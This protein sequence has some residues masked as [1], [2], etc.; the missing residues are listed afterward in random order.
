MKKLFLV[1]ISSI[2]FLAH[3][4]AQQPKPTPT[5]TPTG[6]QVVDTTPKAWQIGVGS[7]QKELSVTFDQRMNPGF[8]AWMGRSSLVPQLD[9]NT[10]ISEDRSTFSLHVDLL[11]GKVYVF[12]LNEKKLPGV[13][14]QNERGQAAPPYFLV[15]QTAGNPAPDDAPPRVAS[16]IPTNNAQQLDPSRLKSVTIVF[17]KPMLTAKHGLHMVENKREVD[18]S[19]AKFQYSADGKSFIL[20]YDFKPSTVYEF[21]LNNTQDIGFV[22]AKRVPL[23]PVG[24]A[25]STGS[26]R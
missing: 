12:G 14:F 4:Y 2:G 7:S 19:K 13:G 8:T 10:K 26:P 3:S 17:D 16:T 23:W 15:F 5:P 1:L 24:F 6:P 11:P 18:L 20:G 22:S 9:L 25:F 21:Q